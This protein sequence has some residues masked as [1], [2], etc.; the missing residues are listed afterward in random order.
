[1]KTF[2]VTVN[3]EN[4]NILQLTIDL[5]ATTCKHIPDRIDGVWEA[6]SYDEA[7]NGIRNAIRA[8]LPTP[9]IMMKPSL[10]KTNFTKL[11]MMESDDPSQ[12]E[13]MKL[14][15]GHLITQGQMKTD[16]KL[17]PTVE[18]IMELFEEQ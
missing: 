17:W 4:E 8:V 3:R 1:M 16:D 10:K 2:Y 13:E 9:I 18:Q 6:N 5:Q 15:I 14:K 12:R 7:L 11:F